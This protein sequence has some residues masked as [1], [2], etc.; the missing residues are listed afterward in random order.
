[1]ATFFLKPIWRKG[2]GAPPNGRAGAEVPLFSNSRFGE[3]SGPG[4][5]AGGA[6]GFVGLTPLTVSIPSTFTVLP[7]G[8]FSA[9]FSSFFPINGRLE[10]EVR[11]KTDRIKKI[12]R[13]KVI[14]LFMVA[15]WF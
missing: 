4:F 8:S 2:R 5:L 10:Q 1:M 12:E 9:F 13:G 11:R 15:P 14:F 3:G 6:S 7:S